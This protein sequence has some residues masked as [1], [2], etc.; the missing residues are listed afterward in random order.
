MSDTESPAP[1]SADATPSSRRAYIAWLLLLIL[2]AA[3]GAGAWLAYPLVQQF[4]DRQEALQQSLAS[5]SDELRNE[6]ME[7]QKLTAELRQLRDDSDRNQRFITERLDAQQNRLAEIS[8]T[9]HSDWKLAEAEYLLKLAHQRV[10]MEKSPRN[11]IALM[12]EADRILRDLDDSNVFPLR[13]ALAQDLTALKLAGSVDTE[14]LYLRLGALNQEV[15][16]LP[17]QQRFKARPQDKSASGD[18]QLSSFQRFWQR[19]SRYFRVESQRE[20]PIPHLDADS[21]AY[22]AQ[23]LRLHFEQ[24]QL[25]L[26]RGQ[27]DIYKQSLKDAQSLIDKYYPVSETKVAL[28]RELEALQQATITVDLP[29][30]THSLDMLHSYIARKH[31]LAEGSEAQ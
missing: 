23:N 15:D 5:L 2:V 10:L 21:A 16:A 18:E 8:S 19:F 29:D 11:A 7:R 31:K 27:P 30:I 1:S 26:L 28:E 6:M 12:Q 24:A 20:K 22:L 3:L 4:L 17:L 9:D 25:A 14:G 13:D